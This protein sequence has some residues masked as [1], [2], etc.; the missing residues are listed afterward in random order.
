ML[1]VLTSFRNKKVS[2]GLTAKST[3][4]FAGS[5]GPSSGP[6]TSLGRRLFKVCGHILLLCNEADVASTPPGRPRQHTLGFH[7]FGLFLFGK[8]QIATG[9]VPPPAPCQLPEPIKCV[10]EAIWDRVLS[11]AISRRLSD[12]NEFSKPPS[13]ENKNTSSCF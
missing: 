6:L 8:I 12:V 10:P 7:L 2:R 11:Q 3:R 4:N 9:S 5:P 1:Y 13:R